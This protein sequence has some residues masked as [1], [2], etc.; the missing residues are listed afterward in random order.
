MHWKAALAVGI[1]ALFLGSC[2]ANKSTGCLSADGQEVVLGLVRDEIE[3][4]VARSTKIDGQSAVSM[5]G[6]RASI[7]SIQFSIESV[8]TSKED[9]N[10]T[11]KF[12]AGELKAVLPTTMIADAERSFEL[13]GGDTLTELADRQGVQS[14][15]NVFTAPLDFTVQPTDDGKSIYGEIEAPAVIVSFFSDVVGA[16]LLKAR[17]EQAQAL[18]AQEEAD[19]VRLETEAR[20]A[21]GQ[22]ALTE[23]K[24]NFQLAVQGIN[25]T[26][27]SIPQE[28]RQALT[29]QQTAFNQRKRASCNLE[30]S[31]AS[32]IEAYK[33][34]ARMNCETRLMNARASQ[35]AQYVNY[36]G[37]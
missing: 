19:R 11:K 13:T 8:R 27:Q 9:P 5:S 21:E 24:A 15:A 12:C 2:G 29:P 37:Y 18:Q 7:A 35:L 31:Q 6:I 16:Q 28:T 17:I 36:D 23:A 4:T 1:V 20:N 30:A 10:S 33:E 3:K 34:A 25:A 26:W 22:A 32:T 14:A